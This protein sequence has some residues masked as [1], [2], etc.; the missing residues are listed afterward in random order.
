MIHVPVYFNIWII[1]KL[2]H[3]EPIEFGNSLVDILQVSFLNKC[4][5]KECVYVFPFHSFSTALLHIF[6]ILTYQH[7][8]CNFN[9]LP[10]CYG[11][12]C[13][14]HWKNQ[15]KLSNNEETMLNVPK[16]ILR[17][18]FKIIKL[19]SEVLCL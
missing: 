8:M 9:G 17:L 14:M 1:I 13:E 15:F 10:I 18:N 2:I 16:V 11:G 7:N 3:C 12:N 19:F 6:L 4:I 5:T